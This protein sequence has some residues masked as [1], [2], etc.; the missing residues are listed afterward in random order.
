MRRLSSSL[1]KTSLSIGEQVSEKEDQPLQLD[2]EIPELRYCAFKI[3]T[4][5]LEIL[6]LAKVLLDLHVLGV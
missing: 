3:Q 1:R 6:N 5:F 2:D 4:S